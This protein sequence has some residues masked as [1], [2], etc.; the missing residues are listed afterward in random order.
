VYQSLNILTSPPYSQT[1]HH[2]GIVTKSTYS[3]PA[4]HQGVLQVH[5]KSTHKPITRIHGHILRV[6][7]L[8]LEY[9]AKPVIK[10]TGT[11]VFPEKPNTVCSF[12]PIKNTHTYSPIIFLFRRGLSLH[13]EVLVQYV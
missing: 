2:L 12:S 8:Y 7:I 9:K 10:T 1:H 5:P 4:P 13:W 11:I 6:H 3:Q